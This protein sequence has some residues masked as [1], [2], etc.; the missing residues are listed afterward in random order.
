MDLSVILPGRVQSN[1]RAELLAV[2]LTCLRYPRPLDIRSDSEYVCK[3]ARVL[4]LGMLRV[5][6]VRD[7]TMS[8]SGIC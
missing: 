6:V 8:I 4:L 3:G 5:I 1:Q 7:L 2:V